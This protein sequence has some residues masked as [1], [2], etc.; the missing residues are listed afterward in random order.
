MKVEMIDGV[1]YVVGGLKAT[2]DMPWVK[3]LI[4]EYDLDPKVVIFVRE[5][6]G[7]APE[8][9]ADPEPRRMA[10]TGEVLI[11]ILASRKS[12]GSGAET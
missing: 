1:N 6:A 9:I 11:N 3:A 7:V 5:V 4:K 8:C 10:P 2:K 12:A